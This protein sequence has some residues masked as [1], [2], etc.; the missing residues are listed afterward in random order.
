MADAMIDLSRQDASS[1]SER[2]ARNTGGT[3][4]RREAAAGDREFARQ[5]A[6][7]AILGGVSGATLSAIAEFV[8]AL[9]GDS[10]AVRIAPCGSS[11]LEYAFSGALLGR[12]STF[13][14]SGSTCL[15]A[16]AHG[17]A[18]GRQYA[19]LLLSP[20]LKV[21]REP[22]D[23]KIP[24][25]LTIRGARLPSTGQ[26]SNASRG[27]SW[28]RWS[29]WESLKGHVGPRSALHHWGLYRNVPD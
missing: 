20:R 13:R 10:V 14:K 11:H 17:P 8:D 12:T 25:T 29:S 9:V 16:M 2:A 5:D 28:R 27:A 6:K 24:R 15:A 22:A 4:R 18:N 1:D 26:N 7:R 3:K 23:C 19:R 21:R